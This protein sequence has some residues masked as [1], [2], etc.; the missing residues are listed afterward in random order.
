MGMARVRWWM[1]TVALPLAYAALV[2]QAT[3]PPKATY[4]F[5]KHTVMTVTDGDDPA[6]PGDGACDRHTVTEQPARRAGRLPK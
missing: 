1:T 5:A 6:T 2:Y 3:R 4:V